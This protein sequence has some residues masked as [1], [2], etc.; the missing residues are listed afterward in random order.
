MQIQIKMR[1]QKKCIK[2]YL[3]F[4]FIFVYMVAH[5]HTHTWKNSESTR[6]IKT[7]TRKVNVAYTRYCFQYNQN[8][9][10]NL[11]YKKWLEE[12]NNAC[13]IDC[14]IFLQ[15]RDERNGLEFTEVGMG[16]IRSTQAIFLW[17]RFSYSFQFWKNHGQNSKFNYQ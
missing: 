14:I 9:K 3:N 12:E 10:K 1:L 6:P 8:K 16:S 5:T 4:S 13:T 7:T 17:P 2:K 15:E 11:W